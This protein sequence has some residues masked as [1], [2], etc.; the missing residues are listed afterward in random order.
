VR[1]SALHSRR[2]QNSNS[3]DLTCD[4]ST[5]YSA[6]S[7]SPLSQPGRDRVKHRPTDDALPTRLRFD[8]Q[9]YAEEEVIQSGYG[10][11]Y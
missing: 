8:P 5:H 10:R 7:T 3:F 1:V 2:Y 4:I 11:E 6:L 9:P